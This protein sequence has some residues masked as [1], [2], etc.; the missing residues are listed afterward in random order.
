MLLKF[1]PAQVSRS[2]KLIAVFLIVA[3]KGFT[4]EV[5]VQKQQGNLTFLNLY[6]FVIL[7]MSYM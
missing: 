1:R 3:I 5:H 7:S 2:A 6:S 4:P